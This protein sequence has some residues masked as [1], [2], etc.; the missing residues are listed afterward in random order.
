MSQEPMSVV[1]FDLDGTI[2]RYDTYVRFLLYVLYRQP[3]KLVRLPGLAIDVLRYKSGRQTNSWLKVRFLAALLAGQEREQLD[4]W[5]GD[6]AHRVYSSGTYEDAITFIKK[7][8]KLNH[9]TVLLSASFDLYVNPL[10]KLLGFEHIICTETAWQDNKLENRL[11]GENCYGEEKTRR[12]Y[13]WQ[14]NN[15][16]SRITLAY[17]DHATDFPL[18]KSAERGI[19][20]NPD[21]KLRQKA[22]ENNLEIINWL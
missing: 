13:E 14:Q 11:A 12:I 21:Y 5:A 18:L 2:T 3:W 19:V 7:H 15:P 17:A 6:F 4:R 20:V 10:G 1:I 16:G 22:L 9:V 8:Q